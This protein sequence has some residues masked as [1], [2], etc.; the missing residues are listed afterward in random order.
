MASIPWNNA[1]IRGLMVKEGSL[2][3]QISDAIAACEDKKGEDTRVLQLDPADSSFT[4]YFLICSGTS[5]RHTQAICD[6][7]QEELEKSGYAPSHVEGYS[8]AEW[9]L[10]DYL[11]FVV[12]IFSE[13][14]RHFYDLERLWRNAPRVSPGEGETPTD[15][16]EE[17]N[18]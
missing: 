1:I 3:R 13:R 5:T 9:I 10:M 7:I 11:N 15:E 16:G 18:R 2:R 12:H 14:A 17:R 8:Q 4:D 6:A